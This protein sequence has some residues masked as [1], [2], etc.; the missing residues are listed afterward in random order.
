MFNKNIL[1]ELEGLSPAT[2]YEILKSLKKEVKQLIR[3]G[4]ANEMPK[5]ELDSLF[6]LSNLLDQEQTKTYNEMIKDIQ[7]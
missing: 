7:G 5:S 1:K 2:R 4:Y 3:D 6:A